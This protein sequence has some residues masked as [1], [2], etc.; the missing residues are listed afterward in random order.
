[1]RCLRFCEVATCRV[2]RWEFFDANHT[3]K[4]LFHWPLSVL[5][6]TGEFS[7]LTSPWRRHA[8]TF[9]ALSV[10]VK[11]MQRSDGSIELQRIH[12]LECFRMMGWDMQMWKDGESPFKTQCVGN[13]QRCID[14]DVLMDLC[15]NAWCLWSFVS[16]KIALAGAINWTQA[17]RLRSAFLALPPTVKRLAEGADGASSEEAESSIARSESD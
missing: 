6:K 10:M 3:A 11:R 12:P 8:P 15:G 9:T 4:R 14:S 2:N 17:V 5:K 16:I 1:M 7:K 13:V